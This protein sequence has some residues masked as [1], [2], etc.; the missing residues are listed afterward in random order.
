MVNR[1]NQTQYFLF[2]ATRDPKGLEVIKGAMR[3]VSPDGL[4]RYTDRT[5]PSQLRLMGMDMDQ[6]Y[7]EDIAAFLTVNCSGDEVATDDLMEDLVAWHPVW[8]LKDLRAGLKLLENS[9]PSK[10][11]E[12]RNGNGRPRRKGSFPQ[13]SIIK[14]AS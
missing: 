10:I 2:F 11:I 13:G 12:V 4:F 9:I 8:L 5:D 3:R 14:F 6:A 1:Q 7:A